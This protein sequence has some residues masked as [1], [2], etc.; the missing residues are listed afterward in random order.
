MTRVLL[1]DDSPSVRE[2]L[3]QRLLA[4]GYEVTP[5][6]DPISGAEMALADPPDIILTDLWMPGV[7]GVQL[8]R[9]LRAEPRTTHVPVVL[10]TSESQRR[11][12]FWARTAG[13]AAYVAKDDPTALYETLDRLVADLA[14]L[15]EATLAP[16]SRVPVQHRLFQQLDAALFESV[17]A[18]EVRALAHDEGEAESV[19]RGLARLVSEVTA[20][21]WLAVRVGSP[22]KLYVHSQRSE[23]RAAEAEARAALGVPPEV[24][25]SFLC[26]ERPVVGKP[27]PP[28]VADV[29][30]GGRTMGGIALG[31]S[32]RGASRDDRDLVATVAAELGGPLRIVAL[33][34]H[35]RRIAMSDPLPGLLNRRAFTEIMSRSLAGL[36]R[37]GEP[38]S[39]LLLDV[40]HF[41]RVNDS[42]GHEAG[43]A[44]LL[45]IGQ[46]LQGLA[47]QT[48]FVA[49]WGGEEFVIGL[50][51][52]GLPAAATPAERV[53][54]AVMDRPF[55]LPSGE[56][57]S[58]TTS[59]G[60][61]SA[62]RGERLDRFVARADQA[63]YRA[64]ARGRNRVELH[65]GRLSSK[66]IPAVP[67]V[68]T[69]PGEVK[70]R[71]VGR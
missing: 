50:A 55:V 26:D 8:C 67:A 3:M 33:V 37:Y 70:I 51:H 68:L 35:S 48:D 16:P 41:K 64:K 9:L 28:I 25:A 49:R 12:R 65:D 58:V 6:S 71:L 36:E 30:G 22:A 21:R 66:S 45:G 44:V 2:L 47:R 40:D 69:P 19:F 63:M 24:D 43:D 29:V 56:S 34:E 1:I 53:R 54:Q 27:S 59:I 13:A 42:Y 46:V 14:P 39:L 23:R 5:A 31:P 7:S 57:I 11:S 10:I 17:V 38:V 20:Y 60:V 4:R 15:R 61:A 32:S 52:T 62:V 18:G